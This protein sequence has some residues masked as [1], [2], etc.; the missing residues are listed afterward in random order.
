VRLLLDHGAKLDALTTRKKT[1]LHEAIEH[2]NLEMVR[3]LL[4]FPD[5][6][7]VLGIADDVGNNFLSC[8]IP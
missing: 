8:L 4:S 6:T 3:F 7:K 2:G 5:V 1:V